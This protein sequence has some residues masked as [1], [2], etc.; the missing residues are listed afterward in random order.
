MNG[1]TAM[2]QAV[3]NNSIE[4]LS[5]LIESGANSSILN[6]EMNGPIHV[7][8]ILNQVDILKVFDVLL[9]IEVCFYI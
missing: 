1:D 4:C 9:N 2:H 6:N 3:M 5:L 7:A 8:V